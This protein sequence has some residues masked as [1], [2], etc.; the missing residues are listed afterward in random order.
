M[1][2]LSRDLDA[3][4]QPR[5]AQV[6]AV[7]AHRDAFVKQQLTLSPSHR[8]APIGVDD[9][10]PWEVFV[11]VGKDVT[12]QARRFGVDVAIGTDKAGRNRAHPAHDARYARVLAAALRGHYAYIVWELAME[13]PVE[14]RVDLSAA[15]ATALEVARE[16]SLQLEEPFV[17]SN[18][19][20]VAPAGD[21]VLKVAWEG[22]T[23]SMNEGDALELWNGDGAVRMLR[24]SG[25]ALLMERAV[26][27]D[28]LSALPDDEATAIAVDVASRLWRHAGSPFRLVAPEVP[29]W[30]DRAE[31]EGSELVSLARE[32]LA[33]LEPGRVLVH[34]DFHHHNLLR[35]GDRFVAIDPK[36]YL[37]D[38]EYDVPSFLW[39]PRN[40]R[41]DDSSQTE[42]RIAAF[43]AAGLN[44]FRIRAWTVIRGAYL[45]PAY[46]DQIR[47][48]LEPR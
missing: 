29:H 18:V 30:L 13:R 5:L 21:A 3:G 44:D 31:R 6:D 32:L 46:C 20:Y 36:P 14:Q 45:R 23:E 38:R 16:W 2:I 35:H 22:D 26:P 15:K 10:M 33:E 24:R 25:R 17:L 7:A 27:G 1:T 41:M 34:G 4:R 11:R 19:S 48:L 28:D 40:N 39:N 43:V 47:A 8:D 37:A 12:D 9:A 42:R